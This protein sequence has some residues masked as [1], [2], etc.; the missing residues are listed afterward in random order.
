MTHLILR[1]V[2]PLAGLLLLLAACEP[3]PAPP[4]AD[5]WPGEFSA[6][7]NEALYTCPMHPN[8]LSL[9]PS[10]RCP[11]CGMELVPAENTQGGSSVA[12]E[13]AM[14]QTMGIRTA[15][16][17]VTT[18]G[19]SV[20][21]F[22]T[23]ETDERLEAV[24]AAR[25][26]GWVRSL[27]VSAIGD[28]VTD[29]DLLLRIY[30]PE[31]ISAQQ[32]YLHADASGDARRI[33]AVYQR[34][35]SIGMQAAAIDQ[36]AREERIIE[37]V[38]VYAEAS[39]TVVQLEVSAGDY[40]KPGDPILTLQSFAQVWVMA[41][42]PEQDLPLMRGGLPASLTFPSAPD[43][44][45]SGQVDYIYPTI[46]SATRTGR[47]RIE[48][49]NDLGLLRPGAYADITLDLPGEP[50]LS[51]PTEA[52]LRDSRGAHVI[53]AL[54]NGRFAPRSLNTGLVSGERTEVLSGL[55]EGELV[56]ASGQFLLD[57]E[58]NLREGLS[59]LQQEA[60]T[61][62]DPDSEV[63]DPHSGHRH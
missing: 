14:V 45:G 23:V 30:S 6:T 17:A 33:A 39:G 46:D 55:A 47:V 60:S 58:V 59:R 49:D 37:E 56:V 63:L 20:R 12:V 13:P 35:R 29:G 11:I 25:I 8:Y 22:G 24:S 3:A 28:A 40:V 9:D 61:S 10:G 48:V 19:R 26:E 52:V 41:R 21:A 43:A 57:S 27:E 36:L 50:R 62:S 2:L 38:P 31:L 53:V 42:I 51:I 7:S 1:K 5:P 15:E 44:P 34:L 18:F 54:G 32:D 16:A 4:A